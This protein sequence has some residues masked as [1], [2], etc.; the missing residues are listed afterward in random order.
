MW[1]EKLCWPIISQPTFFR[2]WSQAQKACFHFLCPAL[3]WNH[4]PS[5]MPVTPVQC[6]MFFSSGRLCV[7][8]NLLM[9][10]IIIFLEDVKTTSHSFLEPVDLNKQTFSLMKKKKKGCQGSRHS[11]EMFTCDWNYI[12]VRKVASLRTRLTLTRTSISNL[13]LILFK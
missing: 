5:W 11:E 13:F 3:C 7:Q 8:R 1:I 6:K 2:L 12:T 4:D 10:R 9:L